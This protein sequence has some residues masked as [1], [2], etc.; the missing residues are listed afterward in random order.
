MKHRRSVL[1]RRSRRIIMGSITLYAVIFVVLLAGT[2]GQDEESVTPVFGDISERLGSDI[3]LT[4]AD[5]IHYYREKEIT[6]Y[7]LIGV[8]TRDE[9]AADHQSGGQADFL[10]ALSVDRRNR[11]VTPVMIDRDTMTQVTTYGVFGNPAGTRVMQICL[12]QAFSGRQTD[13]S[14]N[15]AQAVSA[16]LGGV[17]INRCVTMDMDGIAA[18]NDAV[19]GV[20]VTLQEDLTALDPAM[21]KGETIRLAGKQAEYFVRGR[22]NVADGT[23]ASRMTRQ[24]TY[25]LALR[26]QV[27]EQLKQDAEFLQTLL[28][29]LSG[30]LESDV[31]ENLLLSEINAYADYE[32]KPVQT[33]AG[34]YSLGEDGFTE[35]WPDQEAVNELLLEIWFD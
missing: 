23:N 2:F 15:T 20:T 18:L 22:M 27:A 11:S 16:L 8:D 21:R 6:N 33:I 3:S 9:E 28:D 1:S 19:G 26:T 24:R 10:L 25:F 32:W 14:E 5:E 34:S 12:A 29:A 4:L 35:F 13:G 31:N 7:L 17:K 30:H